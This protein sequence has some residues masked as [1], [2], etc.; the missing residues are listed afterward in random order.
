M[1]NPI[2]NGKEVFAVLSMA[3]VMSISMSVKVNAASDIDA[4][5]KSAYTATINDDIKTSADVN[6]T[7]SSS[8]SKDQELTSQVDKDVVGV[9]SAE[10][11]V[12]KED[13]LEATTS[14]EAKKETALAEENKS[15]NTSL[16]E[17]VGAEVE[18]LEVGGN[19]PQAQGAGETSTKEEKDPN[20]SDDE[21]Q[22]QDYDGSERYKTTDLQPGNVNQEL[23]STDEKKVKDG[24][25]VDFKNPSETSPSKK[26]WG[27]QI[28]IDKKT[29]QRTYTK[30]YVTDSGLV[31]APLGEKPM[32]GQGDKL[33]SESPGVTFTPDEKGE[34]T[35]AGKQRNFNY[36]AS[37]E[38]LKHINNKGNSSTSFGMKDNYTK[39]NPGVKFFGDNFALGYKVN[40]W[41]NE[42]DK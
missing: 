3:T 4:A 10:N 28:T 27:Y 39:D 40:P 29:G 19:T 35:A 31:P 12:E 16:A 38:T 25:K 34:I 18:K 22:I 30:I 9:K 37:E 2:K 6:L 8:D 7:R 42:N 41:P 13:N 11:P 33:T 14:G 1:K 26:E 20:Y 32:M 23:N 17:D 21:K 5:A 24:F 36:E 15:E